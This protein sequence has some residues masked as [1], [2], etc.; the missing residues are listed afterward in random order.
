MLLTHFGETRRK[1]FWQMFIHHIVT[2]TLVFGSW[3]T[4]TIRIGSLILALHDV[5]DPV[6][7]AT[8]M[9]VYIKFKT[10]STILFALFAVLWFSTRLVYFPLRIIH[11]CVRD[12]V[13][14]FRIEGVVDER[15]E[16]LFRIFIGCLWILY[17]L[18]WIWFYNIVAL[19]VKVVKGE[20]VKD[21]R[22]A[23]E[24]EDD[25]ED[26]PPPPPS[27]PSPSPS[28]TIS[29]SE[30]KTELAAAAS[31]SAASAATVEAMME[32]RASAD[33]K[34]TNGKTA[35]VEEQNE[36]ARTKETN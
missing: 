19:I 16:L 35:Q 29:G 32:S 36:A 27:P 3:I 12:R 26:E 9:A 21:T 24:A 5:V 28:A 33:S 2:L 1:D 25:D 20:S 14:I 8:K 15:L 4:N 22:S 31:S 23:D 18:H 34:N 30:I 17:V 13:D 11:T 6:L 10:L 7:Q